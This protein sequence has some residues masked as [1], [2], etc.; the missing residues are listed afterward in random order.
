MRSLQG[1]CLGSGGVSIARLQKNTDTEWSTSRSQG[2]RRGLFRHTSES[3]ST[4]ITGWMRQGEWMDDVDL[5]FL[6]RVRE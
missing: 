1:G 4:N 6:W 5:S 2:E 3:T